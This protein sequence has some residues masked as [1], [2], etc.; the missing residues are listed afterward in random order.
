MDIV[1]V[2][3]QCFSRIGLPDFDAALSEVRASVAPKEV[4]AYID[5]NKQFGTA[6]KG[7]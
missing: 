7:S 1:D 5:W 6:L 4:D 2:R 3:V